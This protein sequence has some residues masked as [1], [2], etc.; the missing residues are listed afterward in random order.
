MER[1]HTSES[2]AAWKQAAL[3]DGWMEKPGGPWGVQ[4][5]PLR[6]DEVFGQF[7]QT[8][9]RRPGDNSSLLKKGDAVVHLVDRVLSFGDRR[10]EDVHADGWF[11]NGLMGWHT[12]PKEYDAEVIEGIRSTCT[13]CGKV[14][15]EGLTPL[16][17]VARV[18]PECLVAPSVRAEQK[19]ISSHLD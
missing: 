1:T 6:R 11:D 4:E 9:E 17:F 19:Y 12:F 2:L 8:G 3:A 15:P 16:L 13:R 10:V 7:V 5:Q 14:S 18:C